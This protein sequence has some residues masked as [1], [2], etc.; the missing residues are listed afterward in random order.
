MKNQRNRVV[1]L[2]IML[3]L[4]AIIFLMVYLIVMMQTDG[5]KCVAN[6]MIYYSELKNLSCNCMPKNVEARP[7]NPFG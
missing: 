4:I 7:S 3:G 2:G 5:G 6:P 1:D